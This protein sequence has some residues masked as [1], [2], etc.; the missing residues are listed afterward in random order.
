MTIQRWREHLWVKQ[1]CPMLMV[2]WS[3]YLLVKERAGQFFES[4]K[5]LAFKT[6]RLSGQTTLQCYSPRST[7]TVFAHDFSP[8]THKPSKNFLPTSIK[9]QLEKATKFA[10]QRV[11]TRYSRY[12]K[13]FPNNMGDN[14]VTWHVH[15]AR[16]KSRMIRRVSGALNFR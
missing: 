11:V 16:Q 8:S 6:V 7:R 15:I 1:L 3:L 4:V 13:Y 5:I 14:I 12:S 2:R 10:A 9:T